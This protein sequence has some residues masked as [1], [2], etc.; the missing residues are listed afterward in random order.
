MNEKNNL[1]AEAFLALCAELAKRPYSA[2]KRGAMNQL[3]SFASGQYGRETHQAAIKIFKE[4][5]PVIET[6]E[7]KLSGKQSD[8]G[9]SR[10][11][12]SSGPKTAKPASDR[13]ARIAERQEREGRLVAPKIVAGGR[14]RDESLIKK[15]PVVE[16]TKP[17]VETKPKESPDVPEIGNDLL[18][19][20]VTISAKELT[21]RYGRDPIVAYLLENGETEENL[22]QKTDRQLANLLKKK[23][24]E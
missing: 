5:S 14:S 19:D 6:A 1:E 15:A 4:N 9:L 20:A 13:A 17:V 11:N 22:D 23:L 18:H 2:Q 7:R 21:E 8:D 12:R 24:S 3:T 16:A 10:R